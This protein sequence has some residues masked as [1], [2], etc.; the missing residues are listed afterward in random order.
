M[1]GETMTNWVSM[2]II[3]RSLSQDDIGDKLY[4]RSATSTVYALSMY[5][6]ALAG[7]ERVKPINRALGLGDDADPAE[8]LGVCVEEEAIDADQ[9]EIPEVDDHYW[10]PPL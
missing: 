6:L 8:W 2:R 5:E 9:D 7:D 10:Q 1:A 4:E 3:G